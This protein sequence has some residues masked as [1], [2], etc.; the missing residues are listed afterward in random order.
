MSDPKVALLKT[1]IPGA[2]YP[3]LVLTVPLHDLSAPLEVTE[4]P[5]AS[6]SP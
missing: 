4:P 2:S 3:G 5:C 6:V 1:Q